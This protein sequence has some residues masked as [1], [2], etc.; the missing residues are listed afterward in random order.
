[1]LVGKVDAIRRKADCFFVE[2]EKLTV[3]KPAES[4]SPI[5]DG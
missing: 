3:P 1:M 5:I 4:S 2:I